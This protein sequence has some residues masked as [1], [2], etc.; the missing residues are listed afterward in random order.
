MKILKITAIAICLI[1]FGSCKDNTNRTSQ[2]RLDDNTTTQDRTGMDNPMTTNNQVDRTGPEMTRLYTELNMSPEQIEEFERR[3]RD[4]R[5][6]MDTNN[7]QNQTQTDID[8]RRDQFL[9]E[10]LNNEQYQRYEQWKLDDTT[11]S[12]TNSGN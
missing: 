5:N 11:R 10:I 3:E 2:D 4:H 8:R 9:R 6:N 7:A 12:N 1:L